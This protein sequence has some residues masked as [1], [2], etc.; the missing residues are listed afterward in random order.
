[1]R[2]H[3]TT[4]VRAED[5]SNWTLSLQ[6]MGSAHVDPLCHRDPVLDAGAGNLVAVAAAVW[7]RVF[8]RIG[9]ATSLDKLG[10]SGRSSQLQ[11]GWVI[12]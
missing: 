1:M 5:C 7:R 3:Y 10:M 6:P 12:L 9:I 8:S 4:P 2:Y 11:R